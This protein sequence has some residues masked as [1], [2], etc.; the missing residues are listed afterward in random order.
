MY[1]PKCDS[2][3]QLDSGEECQICGFVMPG[4]ADTVIATKKKIVGTRYYYQ[5]QVNFKQNGEGVW[6]R[7]GENGESEQYCTQMARLD[8]HVRKVVYNK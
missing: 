7:C 8:F 5:S 6:K 1:C 3:F 4:F 2:L